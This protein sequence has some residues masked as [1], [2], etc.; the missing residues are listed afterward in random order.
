APRRQARARGSEAQPASRLGRGG[1]G[2]RTRRAGGLGAR[3]PPAGEPPGRGRAPHRRHRLRRPQR[4]R[5]RLRP[6]A[7]LGAPRPHGPTALPRGAGGGRGRLVARA[8]LVA[9][10][11]G[12][13]AA[14]LL[15]HEPG[16]G[17]TGAPVA[18][19]A[20]RGWTDRR[21]PGVTAGAAR[22]ASRA[23]TDLGSPE[24]TV[25]APDVFLTPL[26]ERR[27]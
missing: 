12:H 11:G 24:G 4:G 8:R 19:G 16:H 10:P 13:G 1:R 18:R 23:L 27:C 9:G 17:A 7:G 25:T 20:A 22:P 21:G 26:P 15:G 3:R 2:R 5:P 14:L 6:A